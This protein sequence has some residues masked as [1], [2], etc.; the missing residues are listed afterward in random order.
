MSSCWLPGLV[1]IPTEQV[2]YPARRSCYSVTDS[3]PLTDEHQMSDD[4]DFDQLMLHDRLLMADEW[5]CA[6]QH[7]YYQPDTTSCSGV[8]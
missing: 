5:S 8:R 2:A 4:Q 3:L 7:A 1:I 6:S